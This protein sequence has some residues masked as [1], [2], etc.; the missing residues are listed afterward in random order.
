MERK[1]AVL[2]AAAC[3]LSC[4]DRVLLSER[5]RA[6]RRVGRYWDDDLRLA[7]FLANPT[8]E[9][10]SY[11][12]DDGSDVMTGHDLRVRASLLG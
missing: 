6:G 5:R 8:C 11:F 12:L 2:V 7:R 1:R 10:L 4:G 9:K 3:P